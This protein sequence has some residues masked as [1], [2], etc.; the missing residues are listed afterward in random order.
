[1]AL[2]IPKTVASFAQDAKTPSEF[3]LRVF[4][5]LK[6]ILPTIHVM[7]N[8]V[9]VATYIR[10]EM[11]RGI[12]RDRSEDVWQGKS[13]LVLKLGA[14]A[15][16][17]SP[18]EGVFF[19]GENSEPGDWVQYFISD[20]KLLSVSDISCRLLEDSAIKLKLADPSIIF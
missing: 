14:R 5:K 1:M 4:D 19:H 3:K 2:V 16:V 12:I 6:N 10:P 9:L 15:F 11:E 13:G 17:D 8:A 7:H 20:A 18:E